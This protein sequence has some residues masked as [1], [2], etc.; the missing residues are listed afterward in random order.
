MTQL[1]TFLVEHPLLVLELGLHLASIRLSPT[2]LMS[3]ARW[4]SEKLRRLDPFHLQALL[5]ATVLALQDEIP[6]LGEIVAFN[7]K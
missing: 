5:E 6:C 2:A 3:S 1:R 7:V 4:L